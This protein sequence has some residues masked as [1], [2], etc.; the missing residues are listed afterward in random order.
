[1]STFA[2]R[3]SVAVISRVVKRAISAIESDLKVHSGI[4]SFLVGVA[5]FSVVVCFTS[6]SHFGFFEAV[7]L[8]APLN[9]AA[10]SIA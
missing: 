2:R 8:P 1:M 3:T 10:M 7:S 6:T 5:V 9:N 4:T